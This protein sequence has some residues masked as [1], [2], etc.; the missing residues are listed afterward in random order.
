MQ[1]AATAVVSEPAL[2]PRRVGASL[3][4]G[5]GLLFALSML[6]P[7]DLVSNVSIGATRGCALL[8][9]LAVV[10]AFRFLWLDTSARYVLVTGETLLTGYGRKGRWIP[11]LVFASLL[12][13]RHLSNLYKI[14]LMG[15]AADLLLPLHTPYSIAVWSLVFA[16]AGLALMTRETRTLERCLRPIV[17]GLGAALLA[18][19]FLSH[20]DP[21]A[22]L[23]GLFLPSLPAGNGGAYRSILLVTALIGAEAGALTNVS[24]SYFMTRRGWCDLSFARRQ[25][26][27]LL[28]SVACIFAM[29]VLLQVAAAGTLLP[30]HLV[31]RNAEHLVVIFSSTLGNAGRVIFAFGLWA[32]CFSG[33]VAGTTGYSLIGSDIWR[34]FGPRSEKRDVERTDRQV[35]LALILFWALS[36]LYIVFTHVR[37]VWLV[38][39]VSSLT[40]LLMPALGI[41]LMAITS[42]RRRM[43]PHCN[44]MLV[45][46]ALTLLVAITLYLSVRN[47]IDLLH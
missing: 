12:T 44:S 31:P 34:Q 8:W 17:A 32:V 47:A 3:A 23:S 35:R 28:C 2:E 29:G 43:G 27:D 24:Y 33:F 39:V 5:P 4:F 46:A 22:I 25:R 19:V 18:A 36:P 40:V 26:F 11:W 45:N 1:T 7:G 20:P 15:A 6:G 21:R 14:A 42:D 10:L 16:L 38:L 37:P 41:V 13:S 9:V 30:A